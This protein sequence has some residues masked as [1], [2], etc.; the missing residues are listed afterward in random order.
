[1]WNYINIKSWYSRYENINIKCCS[2]GPH[3]IP[4]KT[5]AV[6]LYFLCTSLKLRQTKWYRRKRCCL[7][8]TPLDP[9]TLVIMSKK[10]NQIIEKDEWWFQT[11]S[12]VPQICNMALYSCSSSLGSPYLG[13]R[14]SKR[15]ILKSIVTHLQLI[16]K[17]KNCCVAD[18]VYIAKAIATRRQ[19]N[20]QLWHL[21]GVITEKAWS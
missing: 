8:R 1:M 17:I 13:I 4:S 19:K 9:I 12:S 7:Q 10:N 5:G 11:Y 15:N 2:A 6:S 20:A 21:D 14:I 16:H 18:E 3:I